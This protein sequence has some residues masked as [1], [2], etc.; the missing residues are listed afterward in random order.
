MRERMRT[1]VE[2]EKRSGRYEEWIELLKRTAMI[3]RKI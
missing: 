3:K 2:I 1:E